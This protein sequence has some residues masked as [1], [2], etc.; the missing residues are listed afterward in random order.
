MP[1]L[2]RGPEPLRLRLEAPSLPTQLSTV[3]GRM[4]A[5]AEAVGLGTDTVDDLV[6]ATHEALANV[7]DHAYPEGVGEA[8]VDAECRSGT[9]LVVVR[10]RGQWQPPPGDPGWRG[11]GLMI[12]HGLA[13]RVEVRHG[14]AGTTVK[15]QWPLPGSTNSLAARDHLRPH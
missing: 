9:V 15:M 10:D 8:F 3:R 4:A 6:L 1:A 14:D 5:W 7:A 13:E 11:R 2:A 12:I